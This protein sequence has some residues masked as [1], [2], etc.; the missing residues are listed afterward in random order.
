MPYYLWLL[1]LLTRLELAGSDW[2][3]L[4]SQCQTNVDLVNDQ[5]QHNQMSRICTIPTSP[6]AYVTTIT[7]SIEAESVQYV[8]THT[9]SEVISIHHS[10]IHI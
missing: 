3:K 2:L 4:L 1:I 5:N 6:T 8:Y 7:S 9:H 10:L